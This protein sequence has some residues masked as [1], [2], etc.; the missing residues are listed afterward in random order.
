MFFHIGLLENRLQ[1]TLISEKLFQGVTGRFFPSVRSRRH[2][3]ATR[4]LKPFAIIG[5][6]LFKYW[7][8]TAIPALMSH[9]RIVLDAIEAYLEVGAAFMA[10]LCSARL[11]WQ[12]K[13]PAAFIA[14]ACQHA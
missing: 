10:R 6:V 4:H 13:F 12:R 11:A 3:F 5:H 7:I 9:S 1:Q 14:M 2:E 8:S